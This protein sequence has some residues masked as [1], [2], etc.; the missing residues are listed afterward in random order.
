MRDD[1]SGF[2]TKLLL[3]YEEKL[4]CIEK[5]SS[6]EIQLRYL[7]QSDNVSG[8]ADLIENDND[9]FEKLDSIDFDIKSMTGQICQVSGIEKNNF[10]KFFLSR[11]DEPIPEIKKLKD[12]TGKQISDLIKQRNKLIIDM[13]KKLADIAIDINTLKKVRELS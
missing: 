10:K 1:L 8:I 13:E 9:L 12:L 2:F 6:N 4:H 3:L 5:I 11:P 7:L